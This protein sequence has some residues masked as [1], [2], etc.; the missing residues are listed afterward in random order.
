MKLPALRTL[1]TNLQIL[2]ELALS[3]AEIGVGLTGFGFLFTFLGVIFFF[4]K[5]LLA[6]GNVGGWK[7]L[8]DAGMPAVRRTI[9][10]LSGGLAW[11]CLT[12]HLQDCRLAS[13]QILFVA[14]VA[15]TIGTQATIRFFMRRKNH[16]ASC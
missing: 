10:L 12:M 8:A 2:T 11:D 9:W 15:M 16:R 5:G 13:V 6:M 7:Q 3:S 4:D 1:C 14:G